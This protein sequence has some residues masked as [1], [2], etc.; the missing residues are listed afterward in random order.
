MPPSLNLKLSFFH[1]FCCKVCRGL[2]ACFWEEVWNGGQPLK[3]KSYYSRLFRMEISPHCVIAEVS[4]TWRTWRFIKKPN[5][6]RWWWWIRLHTPWRK[7]IPS[8]R[9]WQQNLMLVISYP[10]IVWWNKLLPNINTWRISIGLLPTRVNL[11]K[12]G[13]DLHSTQCPVCDDNQETESY[14]FLK[15]STAVD[16]WNLTASWWKLNFVYSV[17]IH[18]ILN[19]TDSIQGLASMKWCL[20]V[21]IQTD[22]WPGLGPGFRYPVQKVKYRSLKN[23]GTCTVAHI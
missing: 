23:F 15:C 9:N 2:H 1:V 13:I 20:D 4:W 14:I 11:D 8:S 6:K 17:N 18:G 12:L 21:V 22:L 5:C 19:M 3:S 7:R 10:K 16:L